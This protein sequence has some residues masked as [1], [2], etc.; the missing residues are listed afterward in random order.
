MRITTA[1]DKLNSNSTAPPSV[2]ALEQSRM[3]SNHV[4]HVTK[5]LQILEPLE[6]DTNGQRSQRRQ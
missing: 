5:L 3:V 2:D 1:T 6:A 4:H